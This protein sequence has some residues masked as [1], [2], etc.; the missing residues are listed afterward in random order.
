MNRFRSFCLVLAFAAA[1]SSA[2]AGSTTARVPPV[3]NDFLGISPATRLSG[4]ELARMS[5]GKV[6]TLRVP[7]FWE[8]LQPYPGQGHQFTRYDELVAYAAYYGI[9]IKPFVMGVPFY[10]GMRE[11]A[12]YPPVNNRVFMRE[13]NQLLKALVQRYGP[14]GEIWQYLRANAPEIKA[15]PIRTWQIW[16]EPNG[17]TYWHP[18]RT[19]PRDYAKLLKAS[20]RTIRRQDRGATIVVAGFF[21]HP[22]DGTPM[23]RFVRRLY[24]VR[25]ISSSFDAIGIHPYSINAAG[26]AD[27]IRAARAVIDAAG[28]SQTELWVDEIGWPTQ[29]R[30]GNNVFLKSEAGQ[31]QSLRRTFTM[32]LRKRKAWNIGSLIWYTWADTDIFTTCDLCGYSGLFR[33]DLTAKPAWSAYVDFT[34]GEA[35]PPQRALPAPRRIPLPGD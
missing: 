30:S 6:P 35:E 31:K 33:E 18:Q 24:D 19:A 11:D 10:L 25:G 17:Y 22:S 27:Q 7:F 14:G 26:V 28:D 3:P 4:L 2:T 15:E 23:T 29:A 20:S 16:N 8:D 21:K 1:L 34:G 12:H 13:W 5:L 9:R 32:I